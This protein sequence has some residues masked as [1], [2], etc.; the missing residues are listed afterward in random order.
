MTTTSPVEKA[1]EATATYVDSAIDVYRKLYDP[2]KG[3]GKGPGRKP[4]G[5]QGRFDEHLKPGTSKG[6]DPAKAVSERNGQEWKVAIA[7]ARDSAKAQGMLPAAM[8][9]VFNDMIEPAICWQD[10]IEAFFQRKVGG[11]GY[12][13]RRPDRRFVQRQIYIPSRSGHGAGDIV[14]AIDTSGSIG[15]DMLNR[16]MAEVKGILSDLRPQRVFVLWID[17]KLHKV[18]E[19]DDPADI[20]TLKPHGGGGTDF[21]PAFTWVADNFIKPDALVY[22]TD[23]YGP[24]PDKAPA[25]PVLWARTDPNV[26]PAWGDI[27]DVPVGK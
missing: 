22:F 24:W 26:K 17:A 1:G 18:D 12:D 27:V 14:V 2:K 21:R 5:G 15:Q 6:K 23:L 4:A 16:F 20:S 10:K 8:E 9:R 11:P 7:A 25:Y 13:F 3:G 19:V